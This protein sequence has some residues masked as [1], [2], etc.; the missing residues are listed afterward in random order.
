MTTWMNT[1]YRPIS[2]VQNKEDFSN[3]K[4]QKYIIQMCEDTL[5]M[6]SRIIDMVKSFTTMVKGGEVYTMREIEML[7]GV[8]T[9]KNVKSRPRNICIPPKKN[10]THLVYY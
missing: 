6:R 8:K 10:C 9:P 7:L 2:W 5:K 4:K 3:S 1:S